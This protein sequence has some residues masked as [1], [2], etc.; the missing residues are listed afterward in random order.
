[1]RNAV[2]VLTI[3]LVAVSTGSAQH[4]EAAPYESDLLSARP[5]RNWL[6]I[7]LGGSAFWHNGTF[8]P[9]CN[10][11]F[12]GESGGG[13]M[14]ALDFSRDYPKLG[15]ALRALVTYY[16]VSADFNYEETRRT[17]LVGDNED[18]D[19]RYHKSSDVALRYITLT[20]SFAWYLPKTPLYIQAGLEVGFPLEYRYDHHERIL[21]PDLA[22]FDG[23]TERTLLEES[24]IPGGDKLRLALAVGAGVDFQLS[25]GIMITPQAGFNLPLTKVSSVDSWRVSTAYGLIFLKIRL[26]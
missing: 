17:V 24:D 4:W 8:S 6:G 21:T 9:N 20:P 18:I 22:Y 7:G 12:G 3:L 11:T 13:P 25:S 26:W 2:L 14:F 23:T 5:I 19:V 10:C 16:D 15:F 1:M